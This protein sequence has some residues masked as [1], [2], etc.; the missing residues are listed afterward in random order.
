[1][2]EHRLKIGRY[3][4]DRYGG[5]VV[6]FGRF[7]AI[8][9]TYAAFLA[10]TTRM[11]WRRFLFFNAAGGIVWATLYGVAYY[12][13]GSTIDN[14]RAPVDIALGV[15]AAVGIVAAFPFLRAKERQLGEAAELA[16]PA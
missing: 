13:F 1:V 4:F 16:Y 5:K 11:R 12:E 8:L 6:F 10:G 15:V 7:V 2:P 9:R 14:A 3:V